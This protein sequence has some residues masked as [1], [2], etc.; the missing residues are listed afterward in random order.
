MSEPKK[1][2]SPPQ[3]TRVVLRKEQAILSACSDTAQTN[4]DL[5]GNACYDYDAPD[6]AN[7]QGN[8]GCKKRSVLNQHWAAPPS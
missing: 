7:P 3:I 6:D 5:V 4:F 2:Y 1:P 8:V